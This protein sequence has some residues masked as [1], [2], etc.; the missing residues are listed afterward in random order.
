MKIIQTAERHSDQLPSDNI[1]LHRHLIAYSEAAK[2]IH[3]NVL[4]IGCGEGY[5]MRMLAL[6]AEKYVAIDKYN[7][8]IPTD[9]SVEFHQMNVPPLNIFNENTFDFVV[10]FQVIEHITKD[11]YFIREIYRVLKPGGKLILTT[12]NIKTSLTRNPWHIREYNPDQF[13]R[14]M[15][16]YFKKLNIMGVYGNKNIMEYYEKNKLSVEKFTRFDLLNL[17]YNLP[18]WCLKIP[19]DIMNR[20]NRNK[21]MKQDNKLIADVVTSDYFLAEINEN[22]FDFFCIAEK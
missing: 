1:I 10:S 21:L 16:K 9:L 8:T 18:R 15:N 22:C 12:P 7:T 11:D 14:L 17:Q 4:E 19:Y 2:R 6:H 5:G 20:M 3:G 13:N